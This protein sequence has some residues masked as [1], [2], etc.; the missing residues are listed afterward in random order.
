[1]TN[2][3]NN[4]IIDNV[5]NN[6]K[7]EIETMKNV[8]PRRKRR[9][10]ARENKGEFFP[11]YNGKDPISYEEYYGKGYERFNNKFVTIKEV[12]EVEKAQ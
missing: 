10:I 2:V 9:E 6:N 1:L 3:I 8:L 4:D 12:E 5:I 11:I 7:K